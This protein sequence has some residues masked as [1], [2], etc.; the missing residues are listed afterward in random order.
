MVKCPPVKR[1]PGRTCCSSVPQRLGTSPRQPSAA[2]G[3]RPHEL[4]R[5]LFVVVRPETYQIGLQCDSEP[6][7]EKHLTGDL[8]LLS[9]SQM[10]QIT[11]A[12]PDDRM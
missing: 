5:S 12:K 6:S 4:S 1:T 11:T 2:R 10:A 7:Q 9:E 8:F 3:R